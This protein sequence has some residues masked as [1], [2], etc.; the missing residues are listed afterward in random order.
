MTTRFNTTADVLATSRNRA[1]LSLLLAG[2]KSSDPVVRS[3]ALRAAI[4]RRDAATHLQLIRHYSAL[5]EADQIVVCDA[6]RAVPH[7]AAPTLKSAILE[8]DE[9]DCATACDIV[10]KSGDFEMLRTLLR[11]AENKR[12]RHLPELFAA[13]TGLVDVLF[14]DLA[15]WA[16]GVR[17]PGAHDSSFTRHL[18]LNALEQSL[19]QY[20][21]HQRREI[22]DAFLLLAPVD[23]SIFLRILGDSRHPCHAATVQTLS[24]SQDS[25]IMARLV[26]LLRDTDAPRAA[27]EIIAARNDVQFVNLLLHELRHPVPIRVL[28]NVKQLRHIAWADSSGDLLL[29]LDGRAQAVAVELA[30][31]SG[32]S[33]ESLFNLLTR[34]MQGGLAEGR[35][36]TCRA[37]A[38]FQS[39]RA[40]A[41][42]RAALHDPDAGVQAAAARQI[43]SRSLPDSLKQLVRLLDSPSAEVRDA[44]RS[45]LAEFNFVRYRAMFDLLSDEAAHTTGVLVHKVDTTANQ[46]L[47]EDLNS[48][49][50]ST[51]LRGIEM[52]VAMAAAD[53]M[54]SQLIALTQHENAALR[55]D[56]ILALAHCTRPECES[57]LEA[58]S[59]DHNGTIA[60][61]ARHSLSQRRQ[62]KRARAKIQAAPEW[63]K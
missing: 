18:V 41:L 19:S 63:P 25:A 12:H 40:N 30:A 16:S 4:R 45:S 21:L 60:D 17:T 10:V 44:A 58:A 8:G 20:A 13:I 6:H 59:R 34:M 57:V 49:S 7:H 1:V 24:T 9:A 38:Q 26:D 15:L 56:A 28:H 27:L 36:M 2:M 5:D 43:R 54:E 23:N 31:A 52:A 37:L 51:R 46:K 29:E 3:A 42:V 50:I 35:R 14:Q 22:L 39:E 47:A 62:G 55:K 48:P 32:I 61:A 53:D 33:R 11:A